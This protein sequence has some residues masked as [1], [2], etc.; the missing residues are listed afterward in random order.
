MDSLPEDDISIPMML[1]VKDCPLSNIIIAIGTV[2]IIVPY[3]Q[4]PPFL[5][6]NAQCMSSVAIAKVSHA[7]YM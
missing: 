1:V 7:I 2:A 4:T 5:N 3:S 6:P